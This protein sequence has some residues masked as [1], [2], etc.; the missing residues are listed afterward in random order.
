ML[1]LIHGGDIY[2]A[3]EQ[4]GGEPL[5]FSANINPLGTPEG[6]LRVLHEGLATVAQYPDPLCRA[7]TAALVRA[8]SVPAEAI[9]CGNGASDLIYRL[10]Y[11]L[12]PKNAVVLAPCFAEYE[13]ALAAAGCAVRR[14][15]LR[16]DDDFC[17]TG[18]IFEELTPETDLLFLCSPNNPTGQ[19]V[20]PALLEKILIH[21]EKNNILLAV[22]E[23]FYD[24]LVDPAAH[25][26]KAFLNRYDNLFLLRAFTKMFALAGLRLGYC[27]CANRALLEKMYLCGSPWGVSALA[28]LA[29]V[30]ALT[31]RA[32]LTQTAALVKTERARLKAGLTELGCRVYGSHANYIFF[33]PHTPNLREKLLHGGILIRDCGNFEGLEGEFCRVA[34]KLRGENERL[35]RAMKELAQCP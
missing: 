15:L 18:R 33:R 28:Q 30:Q 32:Y 9:L 35:L 4:L 14:H 3:R 10:A 31:E 7:L 6:V 16:E 21:C 2:T 1:P 26:M 24:F 22:D 11:A 19:P 23:C 25:T 12:C 27:L 29:G 8:E 13:Q 5:D 17:L 20:E 34:V